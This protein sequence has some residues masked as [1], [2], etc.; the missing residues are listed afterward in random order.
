MDEIQ[1]LIE[2]QDRKS[3]SNY[4]QDLNK[5]M[6]RQIACRLLHTG[7]ES[8]QC[9]AGITFIPAKE[10]KELRT[11]LTYEEAMDELG[12]SEKSL[13]RYIRQG[14]AVHDGKI[15]RFAVEIVKEDPAYS[16]LVQMEFQKQDLKTQTE[17]ERIDDIRERIMEFEEEYGGKFEEMFGHLTEGE[18]LLLDDGNDIRLWKELIEELKGADDKKE[19]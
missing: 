1:R 6:M 3:A 5:K 17:E 14:L 16:L 11:Y 10:I 15:P 7:E 12:L 9:I 8:D 19:E 2:I 13:K 18:I 4:L